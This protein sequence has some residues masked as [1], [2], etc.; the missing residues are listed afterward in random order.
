MTTTVGIVGLGNLGFAMA[1]NLIARGHRVVGFRRSSLDKFVATGGIA[2]T[3]ARDVAERCDFIITSLP[4]AE[5]LA[6]VYSGPE[7]IVKSGRTGLVAFEL[8]TVPLAAKL[9]ARADMEAAGMV[10]LDGTVSGNPHYFADRT[11]AV[12]I[13]GERTEFDRFA[14]V[15]RD[16]TDKVTWLGPFGA[17][18]VAK[19]VALYLVCVHTLAAAEAFELATR[20]GLDRKATYEA[21]VGSNATSAMLESRGALM[22]DRDYGSFGQQKEGRDVGEGEARQRG[23]ASRARQMA[24]LT[25]L[26]H[27]LGGVYPLMDV[28]N[29][30]Y[31][32]SV[33]AGIG[34]HDIAEVFE[35]LMAGGE[36]SRPIG[37]VLEI[38]ENLG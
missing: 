9:R 16:M 1:A 18:R 33:A 35:Y 15:L 36:E 10:M 23:M 6:D 25:E 37:E 20:A 3:S 14:P 22:L 12:F 5:A 31:A 13:G 21:I 7:G 29:E 4:S 28:M 38:L 24:R 17:G 26:A 11:A 32:G 19:F 34:R 2:A 27:R 8:S 30:T